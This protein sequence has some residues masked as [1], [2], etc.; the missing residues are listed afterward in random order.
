MCSQRWARLEIF[1]KTSISVHLKQIFNIFSKS[2]KKKSSAHFYTFPPSILSFSP[3][4]LQFSLLFPLNFPFSLFSQAS[5]FSLSLPFFPSSFP[6]SSFPPS[7]QNFPPNFPRVGDSPTSP[8]PSY[9]TGLEENA[10]KEP[11]HHCHT[12]RI[13]SLCFLRNGKHLHTSFFI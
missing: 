13:R 12:G 7:F 5:S 3:P 2:G 10:C 1:P 9:A 6:F 8:T 11:V 4:L